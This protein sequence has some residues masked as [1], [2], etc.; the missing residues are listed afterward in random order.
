MV[1]KNL[2]QIRQLTTKLESMGYHTFQIQTI[3]NDI[4]DGDMMEKAEQEELD[5]IVSALE[6][7][8]S[9]AQRCL[10]SGK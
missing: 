2:N 5:V 1:T 8:I 10:R 4:I 7:H 6:Y 9:F 3:I